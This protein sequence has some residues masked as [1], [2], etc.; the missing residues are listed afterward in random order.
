LD[1]AAGHPLGVL[2]DPIHDLRR[3][4]QGTRAANDGDTRA[5]L[6][7]LGSIRLS[8]LGRLAALDRIEAAVRAGDRELAHGWTEQLAAFADGTRWPW[9]LAAVDHGRA[10]LATPDDAPAL[11]ETALAHHTGGHP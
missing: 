5:A 8:T 7:H 10:L 2:A 4:A 6:H 1:A 3:W 11:F 9:A